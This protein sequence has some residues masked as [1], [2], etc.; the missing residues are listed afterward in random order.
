MFSYPSPVSLFSIFLLTLGLPP[1]QAQPEVAAM[2]VEGF[3]NVNTSGGAHD[4]EGNFYFTNA[5][6]PDGTET[7]P[8]GNLAVL[9]PG[10]SEPELVLT[11]HEA[12]Q[13]R[14]IAWHDGALYVVDAAGKR[15]MRV[16]PDKQAVSLHAKLPD[17]ANAPADLTISQEG[18]IYVSAPPD[19]IYHIGPEGEAQLALDA[20]AIGLALSPDDRFLYTASG[21]YEVARDGTLMRNR[22]VILQIPR[23]SET[24]S[25]IGGM[26]TD[27]EGDLW[28]TRAGARVSPV[29]EHR[30]VQPERR[31]AR[32][33]RFRPTGEWVEDY[34]L[35]AGDVA[36]IALGPDG[37][38]TVVHRFDGISEFTPR[39]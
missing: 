34:L 28:M 35:P 15:V 12:I 30:V 2:R 22:K 10:A 16:D 26:V 31:P 27:Q 13:P 8:T 1:L 7:L 9:R 29:Y 37:Q 3:A 24:L 4:P 39:P 23:T 21:V 6:F 38:F 20:M 19:A 5:S 18:A 17:T 33:H 11:F 25:Y 32:V 36:G 14:G